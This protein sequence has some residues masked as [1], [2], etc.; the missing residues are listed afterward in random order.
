MKPLR[1]HPSVQR[2]I[3]QALN[4]YGSILES[5][6]EGFWSEVQEVL[7]KAEGAPEAHHF[8]VSGLR[9]I[10]LERFPYNIL[11]VIKEDRIRIQVVRH[12]SR[13][14]GYGARRPEC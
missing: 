13:R 8:D 11:Y 12:N 6:A 2:D 4:Y 9:R 5:L 3:K 1:F 7:R 14:P 10:N